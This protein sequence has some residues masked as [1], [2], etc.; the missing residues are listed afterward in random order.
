M[1]EP[2]GHLGVFVF[3]CSDPTALARFYQSIVGGEIDANESG[4]WVELWTDRRAIAFQQVDGHRPPT[5]PHG[6]VPQQAHLDVEVNN[7][8]RCEAL[9]IEV[10]AVKAGTQPSPDEFR[11]LLDPAGHPFCL[12]LREV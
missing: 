3:D 12:V 5:W 6:D 2:I 10:G 4:D 9:V 1:S 11:V 8:D 7:L